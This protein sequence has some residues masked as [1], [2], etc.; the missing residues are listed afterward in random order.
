LAP[1]ATFA[2]KLEKLEA[3]GFDGVELSG[4]MLL[5]EGG[6]EE[7][8]DALK[9][10][11]VKASSICG[12][13]S[14]ELVHPDPKNRAV[15][16]DAI[17]RLMSMCPELGAVGPISVPIFNRMDRLPDLSPYRSRHQLEKELLIDLLGGIA[18]HGKAVG[19][20]MLLEPLNRYESNAIADIE[21]GAEIVRAVGSPFIRLIPDFFHMHIE[22][23]DIPTSLRKVGDVIG[24]IHLADST[25]K[26][27]GSGS[28]DFRAGF[29]ALRDVGYGG[30][31]A[32]ECGLTGPAD[33]VLPES[34]TYLRKCIDK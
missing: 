17:K 18:E 11:R 6:F 15:C 1:G 19:A 25:R 13:F 4:A 7:R 22:Q 16:V 2:G 34:V 26:Q 14:C 29:A 33:E 32:L 20:C 24:H 8:R 23:P 21:E 9:G 12:G 5:S 30:Y 27:P 3:Y 31:M 10:S 28:M